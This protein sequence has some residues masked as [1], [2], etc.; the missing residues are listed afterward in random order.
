[1][2]NPSTQAEAELSLWVH[3]PLPQSTKGVLSQRGVYGETTLSQKKKQNQQQQQKT[4]Y[5]AGEY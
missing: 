1:M 4:Q 3:T 5:R 2:F